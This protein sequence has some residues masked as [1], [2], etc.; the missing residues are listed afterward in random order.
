[1]PIVFYSIFAIVKLT[2]APKCY[3][4]ITPSNFAGVT[5][6][7]YKMKLNKLAK[8]II[9]YL[10]LALAVYSWFV[11]NKADDENLGHEITITNH[12]LSQ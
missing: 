3:I 10:M 11:A 1:M 7:G 6:I 4:P 8:K 12:D 5:L 2:S 9:F